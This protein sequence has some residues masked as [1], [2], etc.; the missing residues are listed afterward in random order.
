MNHLLGFPRRHNLLLNEDII[1]KG[2]LS[3]DLR[4]C[5]S[6]TVVNIIDHFHD[7]GHGLY[8][9]SGEKQLD[10]TQKRGREACCMLLSENPVFFPLKCF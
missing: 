1:N 2:C 3:G 7:G 4:K 9:H 8:S 10:F 5:V 6:R